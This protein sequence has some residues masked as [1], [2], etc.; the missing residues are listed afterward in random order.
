MAS[1]SPFDDVRFPEL[2]ELPFQK[3]SPEGS[4][5]GF[6][7]SIS[8]AS[9]PDELGSLNLLT[10]R[11]ILQAKDEIKIGKVC[12]LNWVLQKPSPAGFRRMGLQHRVF[13]WPQRYVCDDEI[14]MN[15]QCGSQWDGF[16][17]WAFYKTGQ[18]YNGMSLHDLL[19]QDGN[20]LQP[21]EGELLQNSIH[22]F[23]GKIV[24][25]GVLIDYMDYARSNGISYQPN[26]QHLISAEDLN[27]CIEHQ[28]VK[29]E[30]G[31]ILF[32]RMGWVDWYEHANVEER[33]KTQKG[34]LN[35]VGV[36][37]TMEEVKW[38]WDHHF[39]AVAC[40]APAFEARPA[41]QEWNLHDYL[42]AL[43]GTPI[44]ELF[45]LEDLAQTCKD[46]GR[47]TFFVTSSPLNILNGIASPPK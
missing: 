13:K 2:D 6:Y 31:D 37:Q 29:L 12:S 43:W 30:Q 7:E 24:G 21:P 35:A 4:I 45:D 36:R 17:H 22:T 5:W 15:T 39:A 44:G 28:G 8:G 10:P 9:K 3:G 33:V 19:D 11:R 41:T 1:P 18:F 27:K 40:D 32:V 20:L 34:P 23:Q 38:L 46:L 16:R 47:Y 42:L 25:R 14:Q 26:D